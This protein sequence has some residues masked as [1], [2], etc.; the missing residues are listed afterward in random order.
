MT[1]K[2]PQLKKEILLSLPKIV[3]KWWNRFK[4]YQ[5]SYQEELTQLDILEHNLS[6]LSVEE[7]VDIGFSFRET[8]DYLD[9]M[10][11]EFAKRQ[12]L[13]AVEICKR[14]I[15]EFTETGEDVS[16]YRGQL[17]SAMPR[18]KKQPMLPKRGTPEYYE[19]C[20]W[21]GV[22]EDAIEDELVTFHFVKMTEKL[23]ELIEEG[24]KPPPGILNTYTAFTTTFRRKKNINE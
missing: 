16:V 13:I 8:A 20:R 6:E 10:R 24:Q 15:A 23:T 18:V 4:Y 12:E 2:A 9:G 14:A 19:L 1:L 21:L 7:L 17:A 11:K 22:R 3:K 5:T